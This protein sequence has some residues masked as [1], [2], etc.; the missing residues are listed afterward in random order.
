MAH[1]DV[2]GVL[3]RALMKAQSMLELI[4]AADTRIGVMKELLFVMGPA[5]LLTSSLNAANASR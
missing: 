4:P 1:A 5:R 3:Q 2:F